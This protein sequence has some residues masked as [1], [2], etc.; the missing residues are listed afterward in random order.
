M[1]LG[2]G[3][4]ISQG[5]PGVK[6]SVFFLILVFYASFRIIFGILEGLFRVFWYS[7]TP[8]P[9]PPPTDPDSQEQ[10]LKTISSD[11]KF[12]RGK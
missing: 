9:P 3:L 2:E 10:K 6:Y 11:A 5:R 1:L 8:P 7:T 12:H 4:F